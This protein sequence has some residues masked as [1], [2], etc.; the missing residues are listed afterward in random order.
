MIINSG[1]THPSRWEPDWIPRYNWI[2][3]D[4]ES[5]EDGHDYLLV[6][7]YP[8]IYNPS[9]SAF[10]QDTSLSTKEYLE[11]SFDLGDS[12]QVNVNHELVETE[13]LKN[14]GITDHS[15]TDDER[16]LYD[17]INLP[18]ERRST[19]LKTLKLCRDEDISKPHAEILHDIMEMAKETQCIEALA[20]EVNKYKQ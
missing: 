17:F 1:A 18:I 12:K 2:S 14:D 10:E 5:K 4:V 15:P 7:I 20:E 19:I 11:F 16:L 8:R 13:N 9:T 6:I 3:L